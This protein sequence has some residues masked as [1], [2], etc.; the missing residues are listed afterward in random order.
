MRGYA[1]TGTENAV[2]RESILSRRVFTLSGGTGVQESVFVEKKPRYGLPTNRYWCLQ[3]KLI[4][5]V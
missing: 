4:G 1:W 3:K 5:D 2:G